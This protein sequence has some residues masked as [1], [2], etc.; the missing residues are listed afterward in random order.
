MKVLE[1]SVMSNG[2]K[3]QLEDWRE[4]YPSVY[5]TISIA[6]YPIAKNTGKYKWIQAGDSFRLTISRGF[7][8]D[9]EVMGIFKSLVNGTITIE[10]VADHF[11]DG[12][13]A[14][15]YLGMDVEYLGW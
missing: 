3:V 4:D 13:K 8:S 5:N 15:W 7:N 11:W 9:N 2:T 12:D 1:R 10:E 14:K 6:A